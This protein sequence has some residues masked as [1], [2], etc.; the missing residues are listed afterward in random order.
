MYPKS[1]VRRTMNPRVHKS[2]SLALSVLLDEDDYHHVPPV[3][4]GTWL[5]LC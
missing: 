4:D 2:E 3:A 1:V 5:L